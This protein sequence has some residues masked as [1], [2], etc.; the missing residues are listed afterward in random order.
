[1]INGVVPFVKLA[2][3][4]YRSPLFLRP[5]ITIS[6]AIGSNMKIWII[7]LLALCFI[8]AAGCEATS[9][10]YDSL[11]S[12]NKGMKRTVARESLSVRPRESRI[13][14]IG[15][16][17]YVV[18]IYRLVTAEEETSSGF[19]PGF[20]YSTSSVT[21][22]TNDLYLLYRDDNLRYWGMMGDYSKTED[23]RIAEIAPELYNLLIDK[24]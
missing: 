20:R 11:G 18:D 2:R 13:V 24:K 8:L 21:T 15:G 17:T 23:S 6:T 16:S 1:L 5:V 7:L 10:T 14:T 3:L 4:P 19:T 9:V 22:F 12:L